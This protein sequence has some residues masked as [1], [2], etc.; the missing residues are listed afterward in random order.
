MQKA[1]RIVLRKS[2]GRKTNKFLKTDSYDNISYGTQP[3]LKI[4]SQRFTQMNTDYL[5]HRSRVLIGE[6]LRKSVA[7]EL[8]LG[9]HD[10][11]RNRNGI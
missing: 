4:F 11:Y 8:C 7:N 10:A 9:R 6:N 5:Q 1:L 3:T 2:C